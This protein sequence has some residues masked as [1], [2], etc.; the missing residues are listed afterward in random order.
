MRKKIA[1][2]YKT[3]LEIMITSGNDH[4]GNINSLAFGRE[5]MTR[6]T[7]EKKEKSITYYTKL[8]LLYTWKRMRTKLE[9]ETY[10]TSWG[11]SPALV[12]QRWELVKMG[13]VQKTN[14]GQPPSP[15][16]C[17]SSS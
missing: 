7:S 10:V 15:S 4:L 8:K 2:I 14:D 1:D 9:K 11:A 6:I 16:S 5:K 12:Y 13:R 3:V 17:P